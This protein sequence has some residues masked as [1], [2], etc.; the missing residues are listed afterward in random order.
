MTHRKNVRLNKEEYEAKDLFI[1][2]KYKATYTKTITLKNICEYSKL[3][4][5]QFSINRPTH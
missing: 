2:N 3:S 4:V 1:K 5:T